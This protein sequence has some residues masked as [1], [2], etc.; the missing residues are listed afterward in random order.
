MNVPQALTGRNGSPSKVGSN[1]VHTFFVLHSSGH[2]EDSRSVAWK[3]FCLNLLCSYFSWSH[4]HIQLQECQFT[5]FP[6]KRLRNKEGASIG[7]GCHQ[8]QVGV[9]QSKAKRAG[10]RQKSRKYSSVEV[11]KDRKAVWKLPVQ[12]ILTKLSRFFLNL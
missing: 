5:S 12:L 10:Q 2:V 6:Y 4:N 9:E 11:E 3:L 1:D 8:I 7:K